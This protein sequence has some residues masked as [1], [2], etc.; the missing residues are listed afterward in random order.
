MTKWEKLPRKMR[1]EEVK[2]YYDILSKKKSQIILKRIFDIILSL[3]LIVLLAIPMIII[4]IMIAVDSKGGVFY[5]QKRVTKNCREFKVIKF[6]TMV[7]D[8]DKIGSHVTQGN[9]DRITRVGH[10]IRNLRLDEL[11]QLFNVLIGDMSFV[12]TRPE[13]VRY[14]KQYTDVM[15]ATFLLP[16][17]ITS[18]ASIAFKDEAELLEGEE[19]VDM[20][21]LVKV[22]PKKMQYNLKDIEQFSFMDDIKVM[23]KTV[24]AVIK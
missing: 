19:D 11:P 13:A 7:S 6:R 10:K 20:A 18:T 21:Y 9:D 23:F 17:G 8:A 22:L 12:G 1:N 24:G 5:R 2:Y 4:A 15:Y 3:V 14:V 16:A